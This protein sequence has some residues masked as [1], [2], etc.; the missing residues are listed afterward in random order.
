[1]AKIKVIAMNIK[2]FF[3]SKTQHE[4][5]K[6]QKPNIYIPKKEYII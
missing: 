1:M 2:R 4:D 5:K 6:T 3:K